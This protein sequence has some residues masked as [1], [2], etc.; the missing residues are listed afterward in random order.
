MFILVVTRQGWLQKLFDCLIYVAYEKSGSLLAFERNAEK[1]KISG[2]E[3][4]FDKFVKAS[5]VVVARFSILEIIKWFVVVKFKN[6]IDFAF[7]KKC[8][9]FCVWAAFE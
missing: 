2:I 7:T 4:V 6:K 5:E 9:G 8:S 3:N 1:F